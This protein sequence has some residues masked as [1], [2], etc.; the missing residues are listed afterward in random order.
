MPASSRSISSWR[1][2]LVPPRFWCAVSAR[3]WTPRPT[4][5]A[6]ARATWPRSRR[7]IITSMVLRAFL[8]A[9]RI[10][11]RP[12]S[13][14]TMSFMPH[15]DGK[16]GAGHDSSSTVEDLSTAPTY[17]Q[18]TVHQPRRSDRRGVRLNEIDAVEQVLHAEEG[19]NVSAEVP[20]H[21]EIGFRIARQA[22]G[23]GVAV[24]G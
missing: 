23:I 12:A 16:Q 15:L 10:G 6:R 9:L 22:G 1:R 7:K 3:T 18:P 20:R 2:P 14:W 19:L 11:G 21:A 8:I 5:S 13:G 4:A 17:A 24:S